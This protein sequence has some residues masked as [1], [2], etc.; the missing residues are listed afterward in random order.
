MAESSE[1]TRFPVSAVAAVILVVALALLAVL[2]RE[3]RVPGSVLGEHDPDGIRSAVEERLEGLTIRPGRKL[4]VTG[5]QLR[6]QDGAGES[7][8]RAPRL[9]FS[10]SFGAGNALVVSEGVVTEPEI[11]LVQT[12][13]DSWNY[14]RPLGPLLEDRGR[15]APAGGETAFFLRNIR[16]DGGHVVL[17]LLDATYEAR[18]LDLFLSR[19][20]LTGPG[21]DAPVFRVDRA[22]SELILP[23]TADG[24]LS[25]NVELAGAE[26]RLLDGAV[27]F[28]VADIVFGQSVL[29]DARGVWDPAL[30]G[31]GLDM[32]VRG[33]DVRIADLPWLPGEVH[34]DASG[35]FT[36]R[37]ETMSGGR[38]AL[39][40][41][42]LTLRAPGSTATGSLR[43]ILGGATPTLESVDLRLDPLALGLVEAFTGP[44]PY[45]GT[46]TG[47]V[48]GTGGDIRFDLRATLRT[49]TA[50]PFTTDVA[51]RVMLTEGGVELRGATVSLDQVPMEALGAIAPGLP[52]RGPITGSIELRGGPRDAPL[53]LDLRLEAGGGIV[54]VSGVVDLTGSIPSYDLDGRFSG[55]ELRRVLAR[56]APPVE[57]HAAF[58]LEGRGMD[59]A[60]AD[61]RLAADGT[62]TGWHTEAG[63]TLS[64]RVQLGGG[65]ATV[66]RFRLEAG[67][68]S[69]SAGGAWDYTGT[70]GG[71]LEYALAVS[72][73]D[74]LAPYIPA[75]P[76]S[77][78]VYATGSLSAEGTLAGT[79]DRPVL[80]GEVRADDVRWGEWAAAELEG[81]YTVD[82]GGEGLPRLDIRL[83]GE[84]F[85]TAYGAFESATVTVDFGR[86]TFEF[87]LQA[88]QVDGGGIL[89]VDAGGRITEEGGREVLVRRLEA[90]LQEQRWRL[91]EPTEIRWTRGEQIVVEGL[92][93]AQ[94]DGDGRIALTG[95][96]APMDDLN[97]EMAVNRFPIGELIDLLGVDAG[98]AGQLSM[99]GAV[100]GPAEA[101]VFDLDLRLDDGELQGVPIR[102]FAGQISYA[103][104]LVRLEAEGLLG[105][106]A[107][108]EVG[109]TMPALM[110]LGGGPLLELREDGALDLRLLTE[111]FPLSTL[112]PGLATAEDLDGMIHADVRIAGTPDAPRLSG[113]VTVR[114][115]AVTIPMLSKRFSGIQGEVALEGRRATLRDVVVSSGGTATIA[116]DLDFGDL[117]NPSLDLA[118]TLDG[119]E[120]QGV[121]GEKDAGAWGSVELTG[122]LLSP[123]LTGDLY[124]NEGALSLAPFQQ[125]D[126]SA[127]LVD[128]GTLDLL[129]PASLDIDT[130]E[131]VGGLVVRN[132]YVEAGD[133][134]W[135]VTDDARAQLSG[136]LTIDRR[137]SD[138]PIQGTLSG[139][140]GTFDLAAGPI[141]RQFQIVSAEIRFF[142]SPQPNPR[143]DIVAAR[144]VRVGQGADV[145]VRVRVSGTLENPTL[146]LGAADA[147]E[148]P[149][150]ELLSFLVF[151]RPTSDLSQVT[152]GGGLEGAF[153]QGLAYTGLAEVL[154]SQVTE[155]LRF[156]DYLLVDY[157]PAAA[158]TGLGLYATAGAEIADDL[159]ATADIGTEHWG[160]GLEYRWSGVGTI[161][162]AYEPVERRGRLAGTSTPY[163]TD[164]SLLQQLILSWRRRWTY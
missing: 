72:D 49:L 127:N 136:T 56:P 87:S 65:A 158:G 138:V 96:L 119:L 107:R 73:L 149:E 137:G 143:L 5:R 117:T 41:S 82:L 85:R 102:S 104:G 152:G 142:G 163:L 45:S 93:V 34:E 80:T 36:L 99:T 4:R 151:G 141:N 7:F 153:T 94:V 64:A 164:E 68:I 22:S 90:D 125:T 160:L 109:G 67:P 3:V 132:L 111:T 12:G 8:L 42:D 25:R 83:S 112:D 63:D 148:I 20:Q 98:V 78:R 23:D 121:R 32:T 53:D 9:V 76:G 40:L 74:P 47:T 133:A 35:V 46:V 16:L 51:G 44:L 162:G 57:V 19:G 157:Q 70:S 33:V 110:R 134:L 10:L 43:A 122:S 37:V 66:D 58:E 115:G 1:R 120:V 124:L 140:R 31:Y 27:A 89:E 50:D 29:A 88:V 81:Q 103:D 106:S 62:F 147:A 55:V 116:G 91:M 129:D 28:D 135:F 105:D 71:N 59:P 118:V 60:S 145:D 128:D 18:G 17:D 130:G 146:S 15:E 52:F 100:T 69:A 159:F 30:G 155:E 92:E 79:L 150:S 24:T 126:L 161:R 123:V 48:E 2:L 154:F 114:D 108:I 156:V 144:L 21:L 61:V 86:P 101:P 11:R 38:T 6:W 14:D 75:V 113:S 54:T 13:E 77:P 131:Q 39:S 26:I 97:V 139:N 84:E 95:V